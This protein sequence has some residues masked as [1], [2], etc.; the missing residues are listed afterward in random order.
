MPRAQEQATDSAHAP[1]GKPAASL[2]PAQSVAGIC[3]EG[4]GRIAGH[5][6]VME[7]SVL[8]T[9]EVEVASSDFPAVH[10]CGDRE[11]VHGFRRVKIENLINLLLRAR[12]RN[13]GQ[14]L[15]RRSRTRR[16]RS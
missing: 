8:A 16:L 11:R 1:S 7:R 10:R 3:A 13:K 2:L 4:G 5:Q 14:P 12:Q 9:F 15:L 6:S